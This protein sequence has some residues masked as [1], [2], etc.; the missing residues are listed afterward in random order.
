MP[1]PDGT[2]IITSKATDYV[3]GRKPA[4]DRSLRP[5]GIYTLDP[6][7]AP[8]EDGRVVRIYLV[9]TR[10]AHGSHWEL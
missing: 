1:L 2:Y 8:K 7:K 6:N 4:E 9:A 10:F 3:V 5:K